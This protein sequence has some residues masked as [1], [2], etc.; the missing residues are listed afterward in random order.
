MNRVNGPVSPILTRPETSL[1][2]RSCGVAEEVDTH[3][4]CSSNR[5]PERKA[6]NHL[7]LQYF[8][9]AFDGSSFVT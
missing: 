7:D 3:N 8:I 5:R 2:R 9:N 4:I 6:Y 1:S